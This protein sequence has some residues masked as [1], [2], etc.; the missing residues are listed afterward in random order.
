MLLCADRSEDYDL[1]VR[2]MTA[3]GHVLSGT[4][5]LR[6][7]V[8]TDAIVK[9]LQYQRRCCLGTVGIYLLVDLLQSKSNHYC[10]VPFNAH[11][12]LGCSK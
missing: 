5:Y 12:N 6:E 8:R 10:V 11:F 2:G 7:E 9:Q 4:Q 3:I 1:N